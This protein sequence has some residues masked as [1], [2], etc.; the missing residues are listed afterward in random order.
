MSA[1]H[2][3]SLRWSP[4][5]ITLELTT[6]PEENCLLLFCCAPVGEKKEE[7]LVEFV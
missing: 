2:E 3:V 5:G 6:L 7:S 4:P 1:K